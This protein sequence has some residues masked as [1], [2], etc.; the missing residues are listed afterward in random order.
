MVEAGGV[1]PPSEES[2][3]QEPTCL[4]D[5]LPAFAGGPL[6]RARTNRQLASGPAKGS[7]QERRGT[8]PP[9]SPLIDASLRPAGL[10][11]ETAT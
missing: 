8:S 4:A 9:A 6:E 11:K 2:H 10:A 3:G 7:Y 1:E 5:S